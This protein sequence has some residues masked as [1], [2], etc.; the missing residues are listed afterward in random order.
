M[1]DFKACFEPYTVKDDAGGKLRKAEFRSADPNGNG[2]CSLAELETWVMSKLIGAFPKDKDKLDHRGDPVERGKDLFDL[3]RP[4]YIR[5]FNDAKDYKKDDGKVL[6]GTKTATNDDFVSFGEFRLFCTY[7]ITYGT[8]YDA[9][10]LIDG[11]GAGRGG[12]DR[13]IDASEWTAGWSQVTGHGFVALSAMT[14]EASALEVFKSMDDNGGGIITLVEFCEYI[15]NAEIAAGTEIGLSLA[16]DEEGGVG[17]KWEAP[18]GEK[19]TVGGVSSPTK[20][21]VANATARSPLQKQL[22]SVSRGTSLDGDAEMRNQVRQWTHLW[23]K[24]GCQK[25]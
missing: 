9:F 11:G 6:D 25:C 3:F 16:E 12:D 1:G 7:L 13:K 2:L 21:S 8:M 10:S 24:I 19:V 15:K 20:K 17:K 14:D 5:A 22:S 18:T 23:L 4:S